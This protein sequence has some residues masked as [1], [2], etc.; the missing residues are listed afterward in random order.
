N[1]SFRWLPR[2]MWLARAFSLRPLVSCSRTNFF[3]REVFV[4]FLG[5][6][7]SICSL[8]EPYPNKTI[9]ILVPF[10]P[11]GGVDFTTRLIAPKLSEDLRQQIVVENKAGAAG[12][13]ALSEVAR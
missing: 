5:L 2:S 1:E 4:G 8:A 7:L 9:K 11:G 3:T 13:I 6:A 10:P 12:V